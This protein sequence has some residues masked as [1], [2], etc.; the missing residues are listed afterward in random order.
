L[1]F[2]CRVGSAVLEHRIKSAVL[3]ADLKDTEKFD[4]VRSPANA[5]PGYVVLGEMFPIAIAAANPNYLAANIGD[6]P[7]YL[8][9][10]EGVQEPTARQAD[11]ARQA[12]H[13]LTNL[14]NPD[15]LQSMGTLVVVQERQLWDVANS[16]TTTSLKGTVYSDWSVEPAALGMRIVH[17]A[18]HLWLNDAFR[19][20]YFPGDIHFPS[21]W[22]GTLRPAYGFLHALFAFSLI[23]QYCAA[24][25]TSKLA[26]GTAERFLQATLSEEIGK[27]RNAQQYAHEAL[28]HIDSMVSATIAGVVEVALAGAHPIT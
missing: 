17:E 10:T 3:Y 9:G 27:I 8:I 20:T 1:E 23:S 7:A 5:L 25:L 13:L 15:L 22:K 18:A 4:R 24:M 12:L 6:S 14:V 16:W 28:S 11:C 19:A 2:G 26:R 21:P